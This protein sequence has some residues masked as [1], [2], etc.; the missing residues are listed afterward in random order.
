MKKK[1]TLVSK[2]NK[3]LDF[4]PHFIADKEDKTHCDTV[5]IKEGENEYVINYLDLFLFVYMIGEFEQRRKLAN[6]KSKKVRKLPYDV[7][8]KLSEEEKSKGVANRH[9]VIPVDDIIMAMAQW[10]G[11]KLNFLK[12]LKK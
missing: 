6:F 1:W 10:E 9:I 3:K 12:T 5:T 2:N 4:Y 7:S 11:H 8:F